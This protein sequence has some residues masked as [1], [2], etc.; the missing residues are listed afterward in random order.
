[1][2]KPVLNSGHATQP[3]NSLVRLPKDNLFLIITNSD[4]ILIHC[5]PCS[6]IFRYEWLPKAKVVSSISRRTLP[7]PVPFMI[8]IVN[9]AAAE[10][11]KRHRDDC[12]LSNKAH[13]NKKNIVKKK[14]EEKNPTDN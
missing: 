7:Y 5:Q 2:W 9:Q 6:E 3:Y 14:E 11:R 10:G 13:I 4:V 12:R 8:S 1:M